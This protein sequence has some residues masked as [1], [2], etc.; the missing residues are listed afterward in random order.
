[1][2]THFVLE[3][4]AELQGDGEED[5]RV[6]EP[7]HHALHLVDVAHLEPVVVELAGTQVVFVRLGGGGSGHGGQGAGDA[8]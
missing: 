8:Q 3:L 7:G 6:V 2:G 1:M 5:Q 4:L